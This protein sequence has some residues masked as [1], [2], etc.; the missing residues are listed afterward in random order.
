M[1]SVTWQLVAKRQKVATSCLTASPLLSSRSVHHRGC[2]KSLHEVECF[3]SQIQRQNF[4]DWLQIEFP[5]KALAS[6]TFLPLS[7][8]LLHLG[9]LYLKYS[10]VLVYLK[11]M[12]TLG[13]ENL[14]Y[15]RTTPEHS[16]W[17]GC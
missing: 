1:V 11:Y 16:P 4:E 17:P 12:V 14:Q 7:M 6:V 8:T 15:V 5:R 3:S 2:P 9:L 13:I 10:E